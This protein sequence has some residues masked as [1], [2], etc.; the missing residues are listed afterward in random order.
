MA[1]EF[2]ERR[3]EVGLK[4]L[5]IIS[6][7]IERRI[8]Q[9][10]VASSQDFPDWNGDPLLLPFTEEDVEI[11]TLFQELNLNHRNPI[12]WRALLEAFCRA[13]LEHRSHP[14]HRAEKWNDKQNAEFAADLLKI[15]LDQKAA[16][17]KSSEMARILRGSKPYTLKYGH[18]SESRLRRLV[19]SMTSDVIARL[20]SLHPGLFKDTL[21]ENKW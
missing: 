2:L 19:S 9:R 18:L 21:W 12:H 15:K 8:I 7:R 13:Y 10:D 3:I 11:K 6:D 1:K 17:I 4:H 14:D 20:A 5:K 16:H